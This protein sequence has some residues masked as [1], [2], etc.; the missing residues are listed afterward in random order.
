MQNNALIKRIIIGLGSNQ[1]ALKNL[2]KTLLELRRIPLFKILKVSRIYESNAQLPEN[3][4]AGWNQ[5][6]LNAAVLI[7]VQ[8]FDPMELLQQLKKVEIFVG[9]TQSEKWAPR[10]IDLDILYVEDFNYQNENLTIPHPLLAARAFAF[11]PAL[12]VFPSMTLIKKNNEDFETKISR[13]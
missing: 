1:D 2:R 10:I 9:R 7:E 6:Y 13:C 5:A 11:L 3:A 4:P 8:N 12:E